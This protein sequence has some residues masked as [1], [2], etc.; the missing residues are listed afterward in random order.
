ML[1]LTRALRDEAFSEYL[2][3][4]TVTMVISGDPRNSAIF[5]S[6]NMLHPPIILLPRVTIVSGHVINKL[7]I[8]YLW[9]SYCQ[10][11]CVCRVSKKNTTQ[12]FPAY[13]QK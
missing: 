5:F 6:K 1:I 9:Y 12:Y 10:Q 8:G 7:L 11:P 2:F 3:I 4:I 13:L